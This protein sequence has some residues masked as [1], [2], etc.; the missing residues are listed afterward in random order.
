MEEGSSST[1]SEN[2]RPTSL[3]RRRSS[4]LQN[5]QDWRR[6]STAARLE[7]SPSLPENSDMPRPRILGIHH[8]KL[9]VSNLDISLAYYERVLG[10]RRIPALDHL[11]ADGSR[12]SAVCYM[13]EWSS[14]FL[15]LRHDRV[16]SQRGRSWNL[17]TLVVRGREDL[18]GWIRWLDLCGTSHSPL[19]VGLRGWI[20]VFE[21][22][23]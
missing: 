13:E 19:L 7:R 16:Q 12:F 9:A 15:E 8:L 5:V 22:R 10:A 23:C 20:V 4:R 21:V 14:L 3:P 17:M 1:T 6:E 2:E 11:R 18:I